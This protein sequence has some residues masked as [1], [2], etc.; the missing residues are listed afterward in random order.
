MPQVN[1]DT[2]DQRPGRR[3][4]F[5][6]RPSKTTAS[7]QVYK[8]VVQT[9]PETLASR[10]LRE[11]SEVC[12]DEAPSR[13]SLGRVSDRRRARRLAGQREHEYLSM[14]V[15]APG[16]TGTPEQAFRVLR[17]RILRRIASITF[18]LKYSKMKFLGFLGCAL[19]TSTAVQALDIPLP[20]AL[21]MVYGLPECSVS[22]CL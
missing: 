18:A 8:R 16:S 9:T 22:Q 17:S 2:Y 1:A 14:T 7:R 10:W 20:E 15:S 11:R 6:P 13:A 21:Q 3:Q 12:T 5:T 19:A 4:P